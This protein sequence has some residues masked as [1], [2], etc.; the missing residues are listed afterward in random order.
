MKNEKFDE[1]GRFMN[2]NWELKKKLSTKISNDDIDRIYDLAIKNGA[3]GGKLLGAGNGGFLLF[4]IPDTENIKKIQDI[5][6][7]PRVEFK[8]E[9]SGTSLIYKHNENYE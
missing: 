8:F 9:N 4:Y 3:L 7:L 1:F 2:Y 6:K 5:I